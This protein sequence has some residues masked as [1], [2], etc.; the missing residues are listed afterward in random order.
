[1]IRCPRATGEDTGVAGCTARTVGGE[2][3]AE[4]AGSI[5]STN[6]MTTVNWS[7]RWRGGIGKSASIELRIMV[8]R[9]ELPVRG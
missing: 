9:D 6:G 5:A 2:P 7:D 8:S 4:R 3:R 1:M